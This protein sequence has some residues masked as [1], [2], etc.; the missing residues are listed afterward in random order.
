MPAVASPAVGLSCAVGFV[1]CTGVVLLEDC[2]DVFHAAITY[3]YRVSVEYFV[4]FAVFRDLNGCMSMSW[5]NFRPTFVVTL[6]LNGGL[7]HVIRR[8]LVRRLRLFG[9]GGCG[10]LLFAYT[11]RSVYPLAFSALLQYHKIVSAV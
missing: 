5:R 6:L 4:Q 8:D 3:L 10:V 1:A 7:N 2:A 11:S 9:V